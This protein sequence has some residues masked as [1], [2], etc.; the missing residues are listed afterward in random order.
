MITIDIP[1]WLQYTALA[2][3]IAYAVP[4]AIRVIVVTSTYLSCLFRRQW[5]MRTID[6][7]GR[8]SLF[9]TPIRGAVGW[10][11]DDIVAWA[12]GH[13]GTKS[14]RDAGKR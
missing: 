10:V 9:A 1:T 5:P 4:K 6:R 3:A 12:F 7:D 14:T 8:P 11:I 2:L 13:A